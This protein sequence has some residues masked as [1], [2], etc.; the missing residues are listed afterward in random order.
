MIFFPRALT[1]SYYSFVWLIRGEKFGQTV[2]NEA[3]ESSSFGLL[4]D[5]FTTAKKQNPSICA[6][7]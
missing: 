4:Q 1:I 6:Q 3:N 2:T 7:K 5:T